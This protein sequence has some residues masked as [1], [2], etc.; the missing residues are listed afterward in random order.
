MLTIKTQL[1]A[2]FSQAEFDQYKTEKLPVLDEVNR[3]A[4][5]VMAG[6]PWQRYN[7]SLGWMCLDKWASSQRIDELRRL[8]DEVRENAEVFVLVGVGGSNQAARAVIRALQQT[9]PGCEILYAGTNLSPHFYGSLVKRIQGRSFYINVIAKNFET[10]EPG[11]G[12]RVLLR[13]LEQQYGADAPKR[14]I[15]TGTQGS[16]FHELALR[17]GYRFLSFPDDIGGR[18]S[19]FSDVGLFPMLVAGID[20]RRV[21]EGARRMSRQL[22]ADDTL[23]NPAYQYAAFRN[24]LLQGGISLEILSCFEPQIFYFG[25]WWVQLFA[26]SEGKNHKGLYPVALSYSEDLH[27]VGQY[28]QEGQRNLMETFLTFGQP[29]ASYPIQPGGL[30]DGFA[31][32]DGKDLWAINKV[33]EEATIKA[34]SESQVPLALLEAESLKEETF[35]A[36]F[37]FFQYACYLSAEMLGVHPFDQPG[38]EGYKKYMFEGLG[39]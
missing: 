38:V 15:A 21:A 12:F 23:S 26:E 3:C 10:L 11:I 2:R 29:H 31:Y 39:K 4:H 36:L 19:V 25:K 18:F 33:A 27:S 28:V 16:P 8:A 24:F 1:P 5:T 32:L 13:L 22:Y 7:D 6:K 20:A 35:G 9:S 30:Q 34:H 14:V 17:E 37:F